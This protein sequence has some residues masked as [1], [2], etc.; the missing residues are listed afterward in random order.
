[1]I[2][3]AVLA[4]GCAAPTPPDRPAADFQ[5]PPALEGLASKLT[6]V[7]AAAT[8]SVVRITNETQLLKPP[9]RY[10]RDLA[11]SFAGMLMPHPYWEWPYRIIEF[12]LFLLFGMIDFGD[13]RGSGFYI[14]PD[15]V[16]TNAH[17]VENTSS[18]LCELSDG[19]KANAAVEALNVELDLA[20]LRVTDLI[21]PPPPVLRLSTY[22]ARRGEPVLAVGFPARDG[23]TSLFSRPPSDRPSPR[24][25]VGVVSAPN[26]ELG[27]PHTRYLETDAAL[28]PGNSGGPLLGLDGSVLGIATMVGVGKENEGYGVPAHTIR[29][30][31]EDHL[32]VI[33]PETKPAVPPKRP[34]RVPDAAS[35]D[36][37][38]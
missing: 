1:M 20:L 34:E 4:T 16:L 32:P 7:A 24:L 27:N 33:R 9:G 10:L 2:V 6:R 28:N 29:F 17:V 8:P 15:L 26:V 21:G 36:E 11:R 19:R 25:T 12:P 3:S 37:E 23:D 38:G 13:S 22:A 35:P 18:L 30:A 31:F 5:I 14:G